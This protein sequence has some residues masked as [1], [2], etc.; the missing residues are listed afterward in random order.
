LVTQAKSQNIIPDSRFVGSVVAAILN[1]LPSERA[2]NSTAKP[3]LKETT[4][5]EAMLMMN[6]VMILLQFCLQNTVPA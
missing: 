1:Y 3:A 4:P 2:T 5:A 6:V